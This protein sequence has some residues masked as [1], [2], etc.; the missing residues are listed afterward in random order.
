MQ[1]SVEGCENEATNQ[2]LG[3]ETIKLCWEHV[4][5]WG[6]FRSGYYEALGKEGD[7]GLH[8]PI[9]NKAMKAFLEMSRDEIKANA[10]IAEIKANSTVEE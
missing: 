9:W 1:C 7:G 2:P 8:R 5:S 4:E 10:E 3:S 6:Y